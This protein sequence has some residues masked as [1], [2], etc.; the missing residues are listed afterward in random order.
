MFRFRTGLV[1]ALLL[2]GLN[3]CKKAPNPEQAHHLPVGK[4]HLV[5][6]SDC[7]DWGVES[8]TLILHSDGRMEQHLLLLNGKKYD[9]L[10][11][12]WEYFQITAFHLIAG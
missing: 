9:S 11:E 3:A 4:W 12:H 5:I 8:D 2:S 6:K 10:Q 1:L 7:K